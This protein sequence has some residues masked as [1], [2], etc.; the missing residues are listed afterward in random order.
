MA[1][2]IGHSESELRQKETA[3]TRLTGSKCPVVDDPLRSTAGCRAFHDAALA[4][5]SAL[6]ATND[7]P[8]TRP[9]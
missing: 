2:S 6:S 3:Q 9:S 1:L 4:L 7:A 8:F 5:S